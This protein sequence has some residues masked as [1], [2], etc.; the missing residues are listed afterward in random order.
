LHLG[1]KSR[2]TLQRLLRDGLL[3]QYKAPRVGRELL[4]NTNPPG[5][6]SLRERIQSLTQV[7]PS[8]PLWRREA[9]SGLP[10]DEALEEAMEPIDRWIASR[11]QGPDWDV[12]AAKLNSYMG[13]QWPA[14]PWDG[15]RVAT[16]ALLL[17]MAEESLVRGAEPQRRSGLITPGAAV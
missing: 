11:D 16:L 10:T 8:S 2:T 6:P 9:S 4:L 13:K 14:P 1:Y 5:L 12:I 17:S 15:D 7:R 3:E